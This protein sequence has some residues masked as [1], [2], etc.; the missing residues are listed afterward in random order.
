[1]NAPLAAPLEAELPPCVIVNPRSFRASRGNLAA[2]AVALAQSH[3]A[4]V[5]EVDA[6]FRL[7]EALDERL[8]HG[9]RRIVVLAGDGTV[10][11]IAEHLARRPQGAP[12]P[13]LLL[14]GGGR[15]NLTAAEFGGN[16]ELLEKL[17]SA[18]TRHRQRAA[19]EVQGR[20]LL[21]LDQAPAPAR[22]GFF[23]AAGLIDEAIRECHDY[24]RGGRGW[25]RKSAIATPIH[26]LKLALLGLVGRAPLKSPEMSIDAGTCG[27]LA[28]P[29]R[30]VLVTTLEHRDSLYDPYARRG[31][32][33]LRLTAVTARATAFWS[34]IALVAMGRFLKFMDA[35]R[36]YLS[37]R[38]DGV[39]MRGLRHYALDGEEF[40]A[41]PSRPMTIRRGPLI[42]FLQP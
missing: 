17:E 22:H 33:A 1:M 32:G 36:G 38:C 31:Q 6:G 26:L 3:G 4:D 11:A 15:T 28:G 24:Q 5:L 42:E 34:C 12:M 23:M 39:E 8:A 7:C 18:L 13:Q 29:M 9:V 35:Q 19:F 27:R 30:V 20:H 14:L 2:R 40:E 41:D 16:G 37:G 10:H 25:L 21:E